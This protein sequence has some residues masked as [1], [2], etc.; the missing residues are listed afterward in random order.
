MASTIQLKT[1][2][3]SAVPSSLTQGEVAI[4][5]DNG[6][7]YYGSGSGNDVKQFDAFTN[8]TASI[9]SS[10]GV[11][12]ADRIAAGSGNSSF[13][14]Q[15][16]VEEDIV[17]NRNI[18]GDNETAILGIKQIIS[19]EFV[20][21]SKLI[22]E[23][24]ITASGNISASGNFTGNKIFGNLIGGRVD[25]SGIVLGSASD[26]HV[27][28]SGNISASG[29][30][31]THTLG[32]DLTIGDDL[33]V[34]DD[35]HLGGANNAHKILQRDSDGNLK[36]GNDSTS[37]TG[38]GNTEI[39]GLNSI[40]ASSDAIKIEA[41]DGPLNLVG[42][43][44]ASGN[45]S[46]SGL[47]YGSSFVGTA[48]RNIGGGNGEINF[49]SLGQINIDPADGKSV[50]IN[51]GAA[52][53]VFFKLHDDNEEP[54]FTVESQTGNVTASGDISASGDL[55]GTQLDINGF[56]GAIKV[57]G[58]NTGNLFAISNISTLNLGKLAHLTTTNLVGSLNMSQ[59]DAGHITASGNIRG[60]M[61]QIISANMGSVNLS[62]EN[63]IPLAEGEIEG[64]NGDHPRVNLIAP[65]SGSLR[66]VVMR[67][68]AAFGTSEFTASLHTVRPGGT[69]SSDKDTV[70]QC[71]VDT[72]A[73][74]NGYAVV[75][76]FANSV[77]G[78]NV[79]DGGDRVL[80][81]VESTRTNTQNY[82]FT[83]V[84]TW[85]YQE[86]TGLQTT[87]TSTSG[88]SI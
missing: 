30:N 38:A 56:A 66:R 19:N 45:I 14:G 22:S 13:A 84:F 8:I 37:Q 79:I 44:T 71:F 5:I 20:S 43:V 61:P 34:T 6:L 47:V 58:G 55:M 72:A 57:T 27:T 17:A 69:L 2:T 73:A 59:P 77:V 36:I 80:I 49:D 11:I 1:G 33:F 31:G 28:A 40:T 74:N 41:T 67:S 7:F 87:S 15:L 39:E 65:F 9:I 86:T 68:N 60:T 70:G 42:N 64:T 25:G 54:T 63:F 50:L 78:S 82:F 52:S 83:S 32:G 53:N 26:I 48:I 21:G 81:G 18:T 4:N 29:T 62:T 10:S 24:H 85:D 46:A 51:E 75:F 23:T 16:T 3:G 12:F 76:D 35:I 88:G